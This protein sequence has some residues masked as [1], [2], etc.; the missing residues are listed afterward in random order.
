MY[1]VCISALWD[2]TMTHS[3]CSFQR[4]LGQSLRLHVLVLTRNVLVINIL[5]FMLVFAVSSGEL[6]V[7]LCMESVV[8]IVWVRWFN[9]RFEFPQKHAPLTNHLKG[10]KHVPSMSVDVVRQGVCRCDQPAAWNRSEP[11]SR[12][13]LWASRVQQQKQCNWRVRWPI[14]SCR[15]TP[16]EEETIGSDEQC[17]RPKAVMK[18]QISFYRAGYTWVIDLVKLFL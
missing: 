15:Q 14:V 8:P 16:P 2:L 6:R 17:K 7:F 3:A 12:W 18:R 10:S 1:Y 11:I 9:A 4:C 13:A 5:V